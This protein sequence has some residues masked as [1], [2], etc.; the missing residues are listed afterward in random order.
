MLS[1]DQILQADDLKTEEIDVPEWGTTDNPKGTLRIRGVTSAERDEYEHSL[2]ITKTEGENLKSVPN[3]GNV[4][5]RLVV[6]CIVDEQGRRVLADSDAAAIGLKSAAAVNRIFQR[7][8]HLSGMTKK[9][10]AEIVKNSEPGRKE[11]SPLNLPGT[12]E[13]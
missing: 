2:F 7:V 8:Q 9:A 4:K 12:S 3:M 1:R 6:K 10:A 5:A 13:E 11:S